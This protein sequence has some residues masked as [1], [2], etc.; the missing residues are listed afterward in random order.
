MVSPVSFNWSLFLG[1]HL[2]PSITRV[3][4][5]SVIFTQYS[6]IQIQIVILVCYL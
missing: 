1:L 5:A 3:G 4:V 2:N 6:F